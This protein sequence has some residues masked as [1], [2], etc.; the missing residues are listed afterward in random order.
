[1]KQAAKLGSVWLLALAACTASHSDDAEPD[2]G[3]GDAAAGGGCH[4]G[5]M[6]YDAGT[7]FPSSDGCNTCSCAGTE[8][9][10]CTERAC[11]DGGS[12]GV[13]AGSADS[14]SSD[15]GSGTLHWYRTCGAPVCGPSFDGPT[16]QPPC[17]TEKVGDSCSSAGTMCDPGLGCR[18]NLVCAKSDPT[19]APGGCPISRARYKQDIRY[20]SP[21]ELSA[22]AGRLLDTPLAEWRYRADLS[23]TTQLG[24]IIEDVG[25]SPSVSGDHV[26]LYG[27][28]SMAVAALKVQSEQ[29]RAL[30]DDLAR[31]RARIGQL[32]QQCENPRSRSSSVRTR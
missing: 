12:G 20:L 8:Q 31:L 28:A 3:S 6:H 26:N 5:G 7:S 13:D 23:D 24:F 21:A 25:P 22:I 27:Y 32:E 10:A 14:G 17:T 15:A 30:E 11:V 18:V 2:A 1:M 19:M 16:G 4:Y 9:V 29:L